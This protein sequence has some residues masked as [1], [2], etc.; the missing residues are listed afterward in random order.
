MAA[1]GKLRVDA[2]GRDAIL[3]Q[4]HSPTLFEWPHRFVT[5]TWHGLL[6]AGPLSDS[7]P[8]Q[9]VRGLLGVQWQSR[10][11]VARELISA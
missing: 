2:L 5:S 7:V 4:I 8:P 1:R 6:D 10:V 3:E 9:I 11:G